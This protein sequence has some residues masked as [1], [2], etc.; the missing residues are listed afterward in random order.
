MEAAA[1]S[2]GL[3]ALGWSSREE[4]IGMF[5]PEAVLSGKGGS[6]HIFGELYRTSKA[7]SCPG[8]HVKAM[9]RCS[10]RRP[11]PALDKLRRLIFCRKM[12]KSRPVL[13]PGS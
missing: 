11:T 7:A 10:A 12:T 4:E 9:L 8:W 3:D 6:N 13:G 1:K 5:R 2:F